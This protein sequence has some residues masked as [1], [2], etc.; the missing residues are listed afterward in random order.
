MFSE[1]DLGFLPGDGA[2]GL[3]GE[4]AVWKRALS[5]VAELH[6]CQCDPQAGLWSGCPGHGEGQG[7]PSEGPP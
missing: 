4:G 6:S 3:G 1:S 7:F 2:A 5:A